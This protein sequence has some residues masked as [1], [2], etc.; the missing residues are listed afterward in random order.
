MASSM[1][2]IKMEAFLAGH[3][4]IISVNQ[5]IVYPGGPSLIY[6]INQELGSPVWAW[7]KR[8]VDQKSG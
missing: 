1:M 6:D 5:K 4:L 8:W 7:T 3:G 2:S